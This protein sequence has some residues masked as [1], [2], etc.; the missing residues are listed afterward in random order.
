MARER[1]KLTDK[2]ERIL[3]QCQL[4][5]LTT[6]D[7]TQ[8][9]N[10]LVALERERGFKADIAEATA[11]KTWTKVDKGWRII[12]SSGRVYEC[13][14]AKPGKRSQQSYWDRQVFAWDVVISG[15][16]KRTKAKTLQDVAVGIAHGITAKICPENSK[17]LYALLNGIKNGRIQ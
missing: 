16:N 8:I 7:M 4:M 17:E 2:Q 6:R 15:K 12:D 13:R 9:S 1:A 14:K 11:D 5:G 3:V 10:R